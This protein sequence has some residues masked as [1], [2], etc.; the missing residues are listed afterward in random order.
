VNQASADM[1]TETQQP[2]NNENSENRPKH[3]NLL[4]IR[5]L[6]P[7]ERSGSP[8]LRALLLIVFFSFIVRFLCYGLDFCLVNFRKEWLGRGR[9]R[10]FAQQ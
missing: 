1:Q 2:Q 7:L 8:I 4:F 5:G 9:N 6:P 10:D 3:G